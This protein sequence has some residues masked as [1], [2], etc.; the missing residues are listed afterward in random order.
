MPMKITMLKTSTP[1]LLQLD[2]KSKLTHAI[3]QLLVVA[4]MAPAPLASAWAAEP[5]RANQAVVALQSIDVQEAPQTTVITVHGSTA[6]T[7]TTYRLDKPQRLIVD[8][9]GASVSANE[10]RFVQNGVVRS[11]EAVP[12]KRGAANFGRVIVTFEQDA[13]YHVRAEGNSVVIVVDGSDRKL[14]QAQ[15]AQVAM[16]EEAARTAAQRERD[17]AAELRKSRQR[18]EDAQTAQHDA[19]VAQRKLQ[20]ELDGLKK[21]A[22]DKAA[23]EAKEA[24]IS[25]SAANLDAANQRLNAEQEAAKK[26]REQ[27]NQERQSLAA[28][29]AQRQS[30][31]A[32]IELLRQK[33]QEL[34]QDTQRKDDARIAGLQ[35]ELEKARKQAEQLR[36][37]AR[38]IAGSRRTAQAEEVAHLKKV[39]AGKDAELQGA[40]A[41]S[42]AASQRQASQLKQELGQARDQL[43]QTQTALERAAKADAERELAERKWREAEQRAVRAEQEL[44]ART[45]ELSKS[46]AENTDLARQK[47][48]ADARATEVARL[49]VEREREIEGVKL[50]LKEREALL[51]AELAAA[52]EREAAAAKGGRQAE[53]A[54]AARERT[55]LEKRQTSLAG[56]LAVREKELVQA[57]HDAADNQKARAQAEQEAERLRAELANREAV[58]HNLQQGKSAADQKKL[59]EAEAQV[60]AA[61]GQ[62]QTQLAERDQKM[63]ALQK[64]VTGELAQM[65][66]QLE[67]LR[68]ELAAAKQETRAARETAQKREQELQAVKATAQAR[69]QELAATKQRGEKR[70]QELQAAKEKADNR[71]A[72]VARLL[73]EREAQIGAMRTDLQTR[74]A[75][76]TAELAEAKSRE[77]AA[78]K[79]GKKTDAEAAAKA[80]TALEKEQTTLRKDL[81]TREKELAT[82][83]QDA[84]KNVNA[85]KQAEQQA[86]ALRQ[87][88]AA[89]EKQLE[90]L[91]AAG[92]QSAAK[93]LSDA[94]ARVAAARQQL[95]SQLAERD[96]QLAATSQRLQSQ[97]DQVKAELT[98]AQAESARKSRELTTAREQEARQKKLADQ[99]SSQLH[100]REEEIVGL[101][102]SVQARDAKLQAALTSAREAEHKAQKEGRAQDVAAA[103][104]ERVRLEQQQANLRTEMA[105]QQASLAE[106]RQ[107]A[108]RQA[109]ARQKAEAEARRLQ[110]ALADR[111]QALV[112]LQSTS[113][114]AAELESA[115][116]SVDQA[117]AR[118]SEQETAQAK[119]L[120]EMQAQFDARLSKMQ[121]EMQAAHTRELADLRADREAREKLSQERAARVEGLLKDRENELKQLQDEV[122]VRELT[123]AAQLE[124]AKAREQEASAKGQEAEARKAAVDRQKLET[125][126]ARLQDDVRA[127]ELALASAQQDAKAQ[128]DAR[129]QAEQQVQAL[130]VALREREQALA[131]ARK[132]G[133]QNNAVA[134]AQAELDKAQQEHSAALA[135]RDAQI[136]KLEQDVEARIAQVRQELAAEH[137]KR[138]AALAQQ[139]EKQSEQ[140]EARIAV[141]EAQAQKASEHEQK[142]TTLLTQRERE[143]KA[144]QTQ[145]SERLANLDAET[146]DAK[147]RELAA[148]KSGQM[149]VAAAAA[150]DQKRLQREL[151]DARKQ[152]REREVAIN[153]ARTEAISQQKAREET[154]KRAR[155]LSATLEARAAELDELQRDSKADRARVAAAEKAVTEAKARLGAMEKVRAESD[156]AMQKRLEQE[157]ANVRKQMAAEAAARET[158]LAEQYAAR[159]MELQSQL[160]QSET[161]RKQAESSAAKTGPMDDYLKRQQARIAV[162]ESRADRERESRQE[163]DRLAAEE[164]KRAD[165]LKLQL[166]QERAEKARKDLELETLRKQAAQADATAKKTAK[167]DADKQAALDAEKAKA[168][169]AAA[170]N[171]QEDGLRR[172]AEEERQRARQG[173]QGDVAGTLIQDVA[174]TAEGKERGHLVLPLNGQIK[175]SQV[176][177]LSRDAQRLVLRV[178]GARVPS[179]LQKTYDTGG[180]QGPMDRVTVFS[181]EGQKEE[182]RVV[183]D[184][185]EGVTDRLRVEGDRVL[186]DF[187]RLD[188]RAPTVKPAFV[189]KA[190]PAVKTGGEALAAAPH[191]AAEDPGS[192]GGGG[193][194]GAATDAQGVNADAIKAP[195][196]KARRYTG[197]RINLTIKDADIQHVLTFLAKEGKVNIIAGPEVTGKVTFHLENIPWDLALDVILRARDLDYVRQSGVIRVSTRE[198]LRKEFE[199]EVERRQK[200]EDVKQ[201]VVRIIPVNYSKADELARQSKELNSKKGTTSVD[202]RTNALIVKDT[203]EHVAAIE[204]MVRKLDTQTPQV[205]IESRIVEAQSS[206]T[207]DVG[208]QWGGNFAASSL[209][210]NE[211]G[212]SFPSALGVAGGAD[213]TGGTNG[214]GNSIPIITPN[215]AVNLPAAVGSGAGG[216]I[217][218]SLGSLGGAAN[219][220]LRLSAAETEGTVKIVSSPKVLTL[221]NT[222][223]TISQGVQIP[224]SVVSAQGVQ[225]KFFDAKLLLQ[226]KPHITQDGNIAMSVRITKNEPDFSN[227]A[228][229]GNPSINTREAQT[230]L[231]LG[232]GETTVI[233]GIYTRSTSTSIKKVPFLGDLPFLGVL[234]RSHSDQDKRT[235]LLIFITPRIVNRSASI[236]VGK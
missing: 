171:T 111:E 116:K 206:F 88:L 99:V 184:L 131:A 173:R 8:V 217:G 80:R 212:L 5:S 82:A 54:Q 9:V 189:Q 103:K 94:E 90:Q 45:V 182:V 151:A 98:R 142:L 177:V 144:L 130:T 91:R 4:L 38:D 211:T 185:N 96:R 11:V 191:P 231:L 205:L 51:A 192:A 199:Q 141:T 93:N 170:K 155:A 160:K 203:E 72:E 230:D 100:E 222:S 204:E 178:T 169:L 97:M 89:Q 236:S 87:E 136:Q 86:E 214:L 7:F 36:T 163:V 61:R 232:D 117:R 39:L 24:E 127:H 23:L 105:K 134:Q 167:R 180:L 146:A 193:G 158:A 59:A 152:M 150:K 200:L 219:L 209:Y 140:Y 172:E 28:V 46:R 162:L 157:I 207:R 43:K 81:A 17:L 112:A 218:F 197:K 194:G 67:G 16:A 55:E 126:M 77:A 120:A 213:A 37:D 154:D 95:Q 220:N 41:R 215:Y 48:E 113:A 64:Q 19:Q 159:E 29:I 115:R 12:F 229:D 138:E 210:G 44:A 25:K 190:A 226:A 107:E 133:G 84:D 13:L 3:S 52:K 165:E 20:D 198:A 202:L 58:L 183:V 21:Q 227:R 40:L 26:L 79:A 143:M 129:A 176:T 33:I 223:A 156:A 121:A 228:A 175:A 1:P 145:L 124:D 149:Q 68:G 31:E 76:L 101:R 188:A 34:Q 179:H 224:I 92:D 42:D 135:A 6:P 147:A 69:E 78:Q 174:I 114:S 35:G 225:T 233:G 27:L 32:R 195:W 118:L 75:A 50:A 181:P 108:T 22:G 164:R 102:K 139:M 168:Q 73:A 104:A 153:T 65:H 161:R 74:E 53:A 137:K 47:K 57:R 122:K 235:E 62:L 18:E 110:S 70:E 148:Q 71:A 128:A 15:T 49:L 187:E 221:D 83:R 123:L 208:V 119:R 63:A 201:L 109:D 166:A 60:T 56:E 125:A 196:R 132:A 14:N 30:E 234:F 216:A 186:W 2:R 106:A 10:P 66:T 85:R